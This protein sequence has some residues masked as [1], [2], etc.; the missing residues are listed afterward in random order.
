MEGESSEQKQ[1]GQLSIKIGTT[2]GVVNMSYFAAESQTDIYANSSP[3]IITTWGMEL[4]DCSHAPH[5]DMYRHMCLL[6]HLPWVN[7][8]DIQE[9]WQSIQLSNLETG[10]LTAPEWRPKPF[11][12]MFQCQLHW[13]DWFHLLPPVTIF[14]ILEAALHMLDFFPYNYLKTEFGSFVFSG[15]VK[16][17]ED[18]DCG[19]WF[20]TPVLFFSLWQNTLQNVRKEEF[21]VDGGFRGCQSVMGTG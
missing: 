10:L 17:G 11:V 2:R 3:S 5:E 21:T 1:L 19:V 20:W 4:C 15:M 12:P 13:E 8:C 6:L 16:G 18:C 14:K 9:A 7:C